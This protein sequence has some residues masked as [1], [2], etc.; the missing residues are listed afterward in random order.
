[1]SIEY[2]KISLEYLINDSSENNYLDMIDRKKFYEILQEKYKYD[3][4][5]FFNS[6]TVSSIEK[7][8]FNSLL[9]KLKK[10]HDINI[11]ESLLYFEHD[12]LDMLTLISFLDDDTKYMVKDEL[13]KNHHKKLL[14]TKL[15][16]FLEKE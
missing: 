13:S 12:F 11:V 16:K 14:K 10:N 7:E 2:E 4:L 3:Y 5:T 9:K 1:M 15:G 6:K 8:N